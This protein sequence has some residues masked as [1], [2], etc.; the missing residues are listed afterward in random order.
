MANYNSPI[1]VQQAVPAIDLTALERLSLAEIF[2][3][4]IDD[5]ALCLRPTCSTGR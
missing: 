3:L 4:Q 1:V 2:G 5:D